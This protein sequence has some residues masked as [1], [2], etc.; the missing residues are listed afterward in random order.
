VLANQNRNSVGEPDHHRPRDKFHPR[1]HSGGAHNNKQ[2]SG[3]HRIH[4][5]AVHAMCSDNAGDDNNKSRPADLC[6]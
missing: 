5:Q 6:F 1:P 3:H 4:E 2:D